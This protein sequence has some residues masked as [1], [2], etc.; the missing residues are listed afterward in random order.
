M[1]NRL[2]SYNRN[3]KQKKVGIISMQR[4]INYGSFLQAYA[5]KSIIENYD[6]DCYFIDIKRGIQLPGNKI[7][8]PINSLIKRI[9]RIIIKLIKNY[10]QTIVI[11]KY[12]KELKDKFIKNYYNI[13]GLSKKHDGSYDLVIIGSD[14]VFNCCEK[15]I[16]GYS[17]QLFG[18][19]INANKII[20]YA[21]SFGHTTIKKIDRFNIREDLSKCLTNFDSISVRDNNSS[22]IIFSLTG[23]KPLMHLDPVL[24]Y[25]FKNE[26]EGSQINERDY[27]VVYTYVGRIKDKKEIQAIKKFAKKHN[28]KL[29]SIFCWYTWC[30]QMLVPET[31]FDV[32]AYF[33]KADY[34]ITDTFHG[35]IFSIINHKKFGTLVRDS[36]RQ[37]LTSLL[38]NL[39]LASRIIDDISKLDDIMT[40]SISYEK[41]NRLID[42]EKRRSIGYLKKYL[43]PEDINQ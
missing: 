34:I 23:Q 38:E 26:I 6:A 2:D 36:N 15:S 19:G 9:L 3:K 16:W 18:E 1:I 32:L 37:K 7:D 4:V 21:A 13:L 12:T 11:R 28:K 17:R 27:I 29:I 43:K 10:N 39:A 24:I 14:E 30:D 33:N 31:P 22:E 41:T 8:G 5:L 25:D 35:T 20:S 42:S 40:A